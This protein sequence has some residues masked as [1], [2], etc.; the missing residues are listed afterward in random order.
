MRP[1]GRASGAMLV[2]R[3]KQIVEA[4]YVNGVFRPVQ[5]NVVELADGQRVCI[6]V[7]DA[8]VP[9]ALR[10]ATSVYDGLVEADINEIERIALDRG[11]FFDKRAP[12]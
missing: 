1:R 11:N 5:P 3:M 2:V 10:L 6:S 8:A 12:H 4:I 9:E 7:E